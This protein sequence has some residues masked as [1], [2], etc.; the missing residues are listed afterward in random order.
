MSPDTS[1]SVFVLRQGKRWNASSGDLGGTG[2]SA[3]ESVKKV[4]VC[5][6][7]AAAAS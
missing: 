5:D 4:S 2:I 6:E 7:Q 1:H 3:E